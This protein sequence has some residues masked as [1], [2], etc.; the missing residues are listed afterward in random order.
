MK[1]SELKIGSVVYLST[2]KSENRIGTVIDCNEKQITIDQKHDTCYRSDSCASGRVLHLKQS[3]NRVSRSNFQK[4][5]DGKNKYV[6][7]EIIS[8]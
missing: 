1:A 3:K 7:A 6:K 2:L 4:I 5:L 8:L